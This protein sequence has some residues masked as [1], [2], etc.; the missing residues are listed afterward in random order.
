MQY[1]TVPLLT[2][3][4]PPNKWKK[5]LVSDSNTEIMLCSTLNEL[6]MVY[7]VHNRKK[8]T[9]Q[10]HCSTKTDVV[11]SMAYLN[12]IGVPC[13]SRRKVLRNKPIKNVS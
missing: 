13:Q 10:K 9:K 7:K 1:S 11:K 3:P 2:E 4:H 8:Q 5:N 6:S 12:T